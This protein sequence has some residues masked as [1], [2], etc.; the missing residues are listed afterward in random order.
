M[1]VFTPLLF[2]LY[3][4]VYIFPGEMRINLFTMLFDALLKAIYG[5]FFF[6]LLV[7]HSAIKKETHLELELWTDS[8]WQ[9]LPS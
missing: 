6:S 7:K 8:W 9:S 1:R 5:F 2:N 3:E 4:F